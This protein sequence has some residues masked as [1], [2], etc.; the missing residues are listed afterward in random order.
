MILYSKPHLVLMILNAR[1]LVPRAIPKT[2]SALTVHFS[3]LTACPVGVYVIF[4]TVFLCN[5]HN[6]YVF[7]FRFPIY[8]IHFH[9]LLI[10]TGGISCL[11]IHNEHAVKGPYLT[12]T[13]TYIHTHK[14][15]H[16]YTLYIHIY[17]YI[18]IYIYILNPLKNYILQNIATKEIF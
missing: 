4:I 6:A 15:T 9:C 10:Y 14:H 1:P 8:V 12:H 5:I 18:Y 7:S 13:H 11:E 17:I 3:R 16:T 2:T